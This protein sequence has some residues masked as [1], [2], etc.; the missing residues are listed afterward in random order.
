MNDF[1]AMPIM[2]YKWESIIDKIYCHFSDDKFW[3][4]NRQNR[5]STPMGFSSDL[6]EI[7]S[8]QKIRK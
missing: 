3:G 2:K 1:L 6:P 5:A 8:P 7:G 4:K